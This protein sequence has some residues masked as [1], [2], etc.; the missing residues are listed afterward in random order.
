MNNH[1]MH[2]FRGAPRAFTLVELLVVVAIIAMLAS[3]LMPAIQSG[4]QKAKGTKCSGN[5]RQIGIAV[6]QYV[7]DPDNGHHYPPIY[8]TGSNNASLTTALRMRCSPAL[9]T[10]RR[11]PT[12]AATS[13]RPFFRENSLKTCTS[14][15]GAALSW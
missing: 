6:L 13:G 1:L 9:P 8:N 5:L 4:I 2:R 7:A 15:H 12:T 14:T 11:T 3:L 10:P